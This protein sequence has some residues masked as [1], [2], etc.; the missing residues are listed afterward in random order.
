MIIQRILED[1]LKG[2]AFAKKFF[3]V[4]LSILS[5]LLSLIPFFIYIKLSK[6]KSEEKEINERTKSEIDYIYNDKSK[7]FIK[8]CLKSTS[9]I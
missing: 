9:Y 1:N 4:Y 2:N 5:H 3:Y 8:K 7:E 6:R